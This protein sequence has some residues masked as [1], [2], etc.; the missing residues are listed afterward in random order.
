M[1]KHLLVTVAMTI[2]SIYA[3]AVFSQNEPISNKIN[4]RGALCSYVQDGLRIKI[5]VD[6][7]SEL[8]SETN[9]SSN[10]FKGK[11]HSC[12]DGVLIFWAEGSSG[13][14]TRVP[15]EH[16]RTMCFTEGRKG[17][18]LLGAGIGLAIG[19]IV[20]VSSTSY[21]EDDSFESIATEFTDD[22]IDVSAPIS[23]LLF[24]ALI[25]A[26]IR[27]DRWTTVWDEKTLVSSVGT[28]NDEYTVAVGF[29]F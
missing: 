11:F 22:I 27:T 6:P 14:L 13:G 3:S 18:A 16:V 19:L 26:L 10:L 9:R 28:R 1:K 21:E 12:D 2:I 8:I 7:E 5:M 24:G 25:G 4:D 15:L 17:H 29:D 20:A 23:G